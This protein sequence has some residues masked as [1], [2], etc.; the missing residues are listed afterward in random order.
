MKA[1]NKEIVKIVAE[2]LMLENGTTTTLEVKT[3]LREK[4]YFALQSDV[5][6]M[7][8]HISQEEGWNYGDNGTYRTYHFEND[9]KSLL[10]S[11]QFSVN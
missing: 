2:N 9:L 1:L 8:D 11:L 10:F 3:K 4:N 7:L 5:S 6:V